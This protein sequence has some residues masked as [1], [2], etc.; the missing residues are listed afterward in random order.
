MSIEDKLIIG[1]GSILVFLIAIALVI[2]IKE[3]G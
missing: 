3:Q 2:Y 1:M